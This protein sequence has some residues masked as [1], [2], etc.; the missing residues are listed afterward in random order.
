MTGDCTPFRL[1]TTNGIPDTC[2][3]RLP[4]G[5]QS[6]M[7]HP[8]S[9][10]IK[11]SSR[12]FDP[13]Y[14]DFYG[15]PVPGH[16]D[17]GNASLVF[18]EDWLARCQELIDKYQPQMLWFDAGVGDRAYDGVKQRLAAYYYNRALQWGQEA[19]IS[20]KGNAYRRGQCARL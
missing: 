10:A 8:I 9:S 14:A 2:R 16:M 20:T 11:I 3:G 17:D 4:S 6:I 5:T 18:Q 12:L 13:K 7:G 15:P 1:I 19:T